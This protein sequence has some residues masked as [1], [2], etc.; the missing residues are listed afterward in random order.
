[1]GL[2]LMGIC[3][4]HW[5]ASV[6]RTRSLRR[7][8]SCARTRSSGPQPRAARGARTALGCGPNAH[9][10]GVGG[11]MCLFGWL[12]SIGLRGVGAASGALGTQ[13]QS[14]LAVAGRG[15]LHR[16]NDHR[17]GLRGVGAASGAL[18]TQGQSRLAVA[19]GGVCPPKR[20][21]PLERRGAEEDGGVRVWWT[22]QL[23][24]SV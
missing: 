15:V 20:K 14:R 21:A 3:G 16:A 18:G 2:S 5:V 6:A 7:G 9:V 1:M 13:G 12:L 22:R 10:L 8:A 23:R 17:P 24:T 4:W 19:G 11:E